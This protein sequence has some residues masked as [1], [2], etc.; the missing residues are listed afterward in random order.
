[1]NTLQRGYSGRH[2]PQIATAGLG[3]LLGVAPVGDSAV[4]IHGA[5]DEAARL[6]PPHR[7]RELHGTLFHP[8]NGY[9]PLPN[10]RLPGR[11]SARRL[12]GAGTRFGAGIDAEGQGSGG[13]DDLRRC[14]VRRRA[15]PM[16]TMRPY[17]NWGI[18]VSAG[19]LPVLHP[20]AYLRPPKPQQPR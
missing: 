7:A 16:T 5:T 12:S 9:D 19:Q 17:T 8:A 1:M 18:A 2:G 10:E 15:L 3:Y 14:P 11:A 6:A 20:M 4:S 13:S